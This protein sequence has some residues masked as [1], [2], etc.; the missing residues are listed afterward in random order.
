VL[1]FPVGDKGRNIIFRPLVTVPFNQPVFDA[2]TGKFDN[3]GVELAD[4]SFELV[5]A[6][7]EMK[8]AHNGFSG[9]SAL[10][11]RCPPRPMTVWPA[12]S[13]VWGRRSSAAW[14][15]SGA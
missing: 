12:I 1:P 9:A 15:V 14:S 8:D 7:N 2:G 3:T 13:G 6:G 5:Y 11:A 4:T 10:P